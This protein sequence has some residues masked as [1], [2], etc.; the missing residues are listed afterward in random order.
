MLG[1]LTIKEFSERQEIYDKATQ[2]LLERI[3]KNELD[4][5]LNQNY[6][7]IEPGFLGFVDTY[8]FLS[9][10]IPFDWA[11]YDFGC[12]YAPQAYFFERHTLYVAVNFEDPCRR[13]ERFSTPN[14]LF[15]GMKIEDWLSLYGDTVNP[16]KSF[17]ICNYVGRE[18]NKRVIKSVFENCYTFY[19]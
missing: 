19:P 7:D 1:N 9:E 14:M 6:V 8:Y 11:I 18:E 10:L 12:A 16:Q 13:V 3:P 5:V 2:W 17:A 15:Y 4:R